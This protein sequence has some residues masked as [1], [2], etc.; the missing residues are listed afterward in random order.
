MDN[1]KHTKETLIDME[2]EEV[3]SLTKVESLSIIGIIFT[4]VINLFLLPIFLLPLW[5][6]FFT[7]NPK[8]EVLVLFWG[9][10]SKVCKTPGV[11]WYNFIGRSSIKVSTR[12]QTIDIKKM[13]VV[14]LNG[15]PIIVSGIV[16]FQIVDSIR[17][18]FDVDNVNA[19][20][21]KQALAVLKKVCSRYPYES[22]DGHSLQRESDKVGRE[23]I[24]ILQKKAVICGAKIHSFDLTDLQYAPEI[25]QGML[26]RQQAQ[27]LLD[28]RKVVVDGAVGIVTGAV[29]S[30]AQTGVKLTDRD[31]AK[32]IS[33]LLSVL[34][35][36]SRVTPT[37]SISES[38]DGA[39]SNDDS[40]LIKTLNQ[41]NLTLKL[42]PGQ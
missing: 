17:A 36:E 21:E 37:F 13:T 22:K 33:N 15:N 24:T 23:M 8:E 26:V 31:S 28:A 32:L 16:T 11:Y 5:A 19:Y 3:P 6:S 25:A 14:D 42:R 29:H 18:A 9:K 30:L 40:E 41:L 7:V 1:D 10:L 34:C 12:T 20:L 2:D 4:F 35:S 27:A 39:N 38:V